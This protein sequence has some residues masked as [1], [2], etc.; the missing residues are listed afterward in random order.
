MVGHA[1]LAFPEKF[2]PKRN[3][4]IEGGKGKFYSLQLRWKKEEIQTMILAHIKKIKF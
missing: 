2:D 4:W 3:T 1:Y